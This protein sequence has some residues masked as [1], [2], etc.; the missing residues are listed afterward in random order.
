MP[1]MRRHTWRWPSVDHFGISVPSEVKKI[2]VTR[3]QQLTDKAVQT[4]EWSGI[5]RPR[6]LRANSARIS[7]AFLFAF[8]LEARDVYRCPVTVEMAD[9]ALFAFPLDMAV[10]D[11]QELPTL[12][13]EEVVD[14]LHFFLTRGPF[15]PVE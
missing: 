9:G 10:S 1:F 14:L 5:G 8:S 3:L 11:Y 15:L 6:W 12:T 13:P 2:D 4:S 7:S